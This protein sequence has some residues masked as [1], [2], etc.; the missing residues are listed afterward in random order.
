MH[1]IG[2]ASMAYDFFPKTKDE[3][4][5]RTQSHPPAIK[6]DLVLLFEYLKEK[7]PAVETP[8]NLDL[9]KRGSANVTRMIEQDTDMNTIKSVSN[10][11][12][13]SIKFGNGSSGNRGKNN[14]GNLFE[15]Q[16]AEALLKWYNGEKVTDSMMLTSIEHL[17]E[18][19]NLRGTK[20]LKIDVVG[21]ENTKRPLYFTPKIGLSNPKGSGT[22]IGKSVTDITLIKDGTEEIYLS[23]KMGTTVTFFNVGIRTILPPDHIQ[24]YN[25][26]N[27]NGCKLLDLFG[28]D[29]K[30][31]CDV[32]NGKLKRGKVVNTRPNQTNM[33]SLMET[34]IGKGY[35]IIH[36]VSGRI[37]SKKMDSDALRKAATVNTCKV[38]YGGKTGTGKRIDMEMESQTYKFKIN[39][40][41]TQGKDGYP[42]RMMCDFSYK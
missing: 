22:D 28:I 39:I 6:S 20:K 27:P 24:T 9:S 11:E 29:Y 33:K 23:L 42:T 17:D 34:G 38:Y 1:P 2:N 8:I 7:F 15:P 41:D 3:L 4:I 30:L 25:L 5:R 12:K 14:R 32:F 35:H 18:L 10:I 26:T 19:Y 40:R 13:L 36:K 21:G 37:I 16:Y 31:F